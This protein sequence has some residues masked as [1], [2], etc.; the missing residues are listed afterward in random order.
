M[1]KA[2]ELESVHITA[3]ELLPI[4]VACAHQWQGCTIR[5]LCDGTFQGSKMRQLTTCT[6]HPLLFLQIALKS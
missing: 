3:K 2:V 5:C 1:A 6:R 4:M